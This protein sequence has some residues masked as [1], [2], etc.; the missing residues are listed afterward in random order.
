[1]LDGVIFV[2]RTKDPEDLALLQKLLESED[3]YQ[4]W[5]VEMSDED[6]FSSGFGNSYDQV[7]DDVM[8]VKIDDDI[9]SFNCERISTPVVLNNAGFYGR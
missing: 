5:Q 2:E 4:K 8:Y 7:E 6:N 1:M 9:V 3:T